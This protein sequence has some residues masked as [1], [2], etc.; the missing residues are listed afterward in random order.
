[1]DVL[2]EIARQGELSVMAIQLGMLVHDV[3]QRSHDY[4]EVFALS[5][6]IG[7]TN[8]SQQQEELLFLKHGTSFVIRPI[9]SFVKH[10]D[11]ILYLFANHQT[12]LVPIFIYIKFCY[13]KLYYG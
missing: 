1:M 9:C 13:L 3:S 7:M 10:L 5:R 4:H 12:L 11:N 8:G 6:D 2:L